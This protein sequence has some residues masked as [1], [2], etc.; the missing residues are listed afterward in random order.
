MSGGAKL[1]LLVVVVLAVGVG[2]TL[3]LKKDTLLNPSVGPD[4]GASSDVAE[5]NRQAEDSVAEVPE[6]AADE[7]PVEEAP[8]AYAEEQRAFLAENAKKDG[9]TVTESGLQFRI[10]SESGKADKPSATDIVQVHYRGRLTDGIE[11]DSSYNYGEPL[12]FP[13]NEVIKGWTEGVQLMSVGDVYEF[14]IPSEL[15]YGV[16]G[17]GDEIP[18]HSVLIF[19]V[20]LLDIIRP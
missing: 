16:D 12:E 2:G 1:G 6:P 14:T 15:G 19:E 3:Y 17:A 20:E 13:L 4:T 7:I 8:G 10:L 5:V 18:G 9:I 11:F